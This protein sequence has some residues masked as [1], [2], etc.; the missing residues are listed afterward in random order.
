[1]KPNAQLVYSNAPGESV[2]IPADC[3][4]PGPGQMLGTEAERLCELAGREC[5]DSLGAGRDSTAFHHHILE[6][7]HLSIY[8]HFNFTIGIPGLGL[9][10]PAHAAVQFE[11][12]LDLLN[13]PGVYCRVGDVYPDVLRV[14]LNL[15]TV[16]EWSK[17]RPPHREPSP[18]P[19][20]IQHLAHQLAP[21]VV[22]KP[23]G[24]DP[25][26][27]RWPVGWVGTHLGGM[28]PV[29]DEERWVTLR[30]TGSRGFSHE[31]V[32]HG[33]RTAISQRSTRY[34]DEDESPW[35]LHPLARQLRGDPANAPWF[36]KVAH[37][38]ALSREVY[39]DT[40][41]LGSAELA[42]RGVDKGTARKQSRG[43]GRGFLGNALGTSLIFSAS[44]AQW[45]RMLAM[46]CHPA[47]DAEI[48]ESAAAAL[49]CLWDSPFGDRFR[50]LRLVPSPGGLGE[51]LEG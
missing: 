31:Q 28:H 11:S 5:Y 32:R 17:W 18:C 13:R 44:V 39:A 48:R 25:A 42:A 3:G 24:F 8:E 37:L 33:D 16:L 51:V 27:A 34:V 12:V 1:M 2:A 21:Y 15:R 36:A 49:R 29:D 41:A 4:G 40:V 43:A 6:V 35:C 47:A 30:L 46:R 26:A 19:A 38:M 22:A 50:D 7:G 20:A 14:T 45:R 9:F 23:E 10:D